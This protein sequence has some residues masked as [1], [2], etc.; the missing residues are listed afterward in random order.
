MQRKLNTVA[1]QVEDMGRQQLVKNQEYVRRI[2]NLAGCSGV[3]QMWSLMSRIQAD[4][5][6]DVTQQLKFS[7]L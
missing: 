1:D 4:H 7:H 3:K 2:S 6:L 5:K